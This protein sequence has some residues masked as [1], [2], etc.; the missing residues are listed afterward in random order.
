MDTFHH[1]TVRHNKKSLAWLSVALGVVL[2]A[3]LLSP[4]KALAVD[5][6]VESAVVNHQKSTYDPDQEGLRVILGAKAL[7]PSKGSLW[8]LTQASMSY[9]GVNNLTPFPFTAGFGLRYYLKPLS[10]TVKPYVATTLNYQQN[11]TTCFYN[12]VD[13]VERPPCKHHVAY[14]AGYLG[15]TLDISSRFYAYLEGPLF[16]A[17]FWRHIIYPEDRETTIMGLDFVGTRAVLRR[18]LAGLALRL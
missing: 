2:M 9:G 14:A 13:E 18:V 5:L 17:V 8:W 11:Q 6:A 3:Y 16:A 4:H 12:A 10:S 7:M 1:H 15:L